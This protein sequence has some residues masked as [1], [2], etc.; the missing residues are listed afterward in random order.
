M[1]GRARGGAATAGRAGGLA[2]PYRQ[3]LV[4]RYFEEL[5][6]AEIARRL[7]VPAGT[8][9]WR[10]K[11]ALDELR[12]QLD[13]RHGGRREVWTAA[14]LPLAGPSVLRPWAGWP[15]VF[16]MAGA[17][18]ALGLVFTRCG[19]EPPLVPSRAGTPWAMAI[20]ASRVPAFRIGAPATVD[21]LATCQREVQRLRAERTTLEVERRKLASPA[22]RF[23]EGAPNPTA[24]A[25]LEPTIARSLRDRPGAPQFSLEC[26]TWACRLV[27]LTPTEADPAWR[28]GWNNLLLSDEDVRE[29]V[30]LAQPTGGNPTKDA[31]TGEALTEHEIF[32]PLGHPSGALTE[33][34]GPPPPV[35]EAPLP[36]TAKS[37]AAERDRLRLQ[38]REHRAYIDARGSIRERFAALAPSS[39][40]RHW[41]TPPSPTSPTGETSAASA[42]AG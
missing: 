15:V 38:I 20:F 3:T 27:M 23:Q 42:Q 24:F 1:A 4:L 30:Y 32:L 14:L 25:A 40:P 7:H 39:K 13:E 31:V 22:E 34:A 26:R 2:E 10:L 21:D 28:G 6:G 17:T 16:G 9:R 35:S 11:V 18:L 41:P 5:S 19:V 12:R 8:V 36:D 37:C 29:R 33:W